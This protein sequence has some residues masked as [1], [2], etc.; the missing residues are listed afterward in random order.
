MRTFRAQQVH[1]W[2]YLRQAE[3][4]EQMT[5]LSK[6][7]RKL[8]SD[9]FTLR[10]LEIKKT[11]T[12]RDGSRKYLFELH[13]GNLI[14]SVLI[15]EKNHDTLCISSQVG[16]AQGCRFCLTSRG[17]FVRNLS[18]GEIISQVSDI[19]RDI[20]PQGKLTNV[21]LMGM[22]EP[23]ANY[24]NVVAAL[25]I[26]TDGDSGL[27]ISTRRVTLS[28]AGLVPNIPRLGR[29]VQVNLAV[30]L[31]AAD[32]E[33]RNGLMPI[34]RKYP[35]EKLLAACKAYPLQNRR[36]ITFEYILIKGV[37]DSPAEARRLAALLRPV[38][39]KINLIPFNVHAESTFEC[40]DEATILEFQQILT[41]D[42][43]TVMI[44]RSKG[45]DIS[46]A[47]GQLRAKARL[48][49]RR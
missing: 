36:K 8:L 10:R 5:D 13:D 46:A 34:N 38:R 25:N 43:Y 39:A 11:E 29:D 9:H 31:N 40:P 17:G 32:N 22:G 24:D 2:I 30:S 37:N 48:D 1:K 44:R 4:F 49:V 27:K 26:I 21:V 41:N 20:G 6:A 18:A 7:A 23:L 42:N 3:T 16:C 14:E 28:T 12:S 19:R 47:C 45:G 33:T 35:I 15:P